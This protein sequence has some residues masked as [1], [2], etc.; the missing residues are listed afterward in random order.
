MPDQPEKTTTEDGAVE[1]RLK[2]ELHR[3]DGPAVERPDGTKGWF[4]RGKQHREDG[5]AIEY[6]DGS[7]DWYLIGQ[8]VTE[9]VV[10]DAA[11]REA[12]IENYKSS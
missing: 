2:G 8:Q 7:K 4:S 10:M 12:F 3:E 1:W 5:P 11:K 9:E 6:D